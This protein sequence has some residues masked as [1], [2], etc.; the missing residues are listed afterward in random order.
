MNPSYFAVFFLLIVIFISLRNRKNE[1]TAFVMKRRK[2]GRTSTMASVVER[3]INKECI[4]YTLGGYQIS[5]VIEGTA[6]G[7]V[8][9]NDSGN[10][11]V[12]NLDYIVRVREYPKNKKG[13]KKSIVSD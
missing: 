10:V 3:F 1:E 4:V 13:K 9:V 5:G 12:L 11:E 8:T 2:K 6:D 7:W